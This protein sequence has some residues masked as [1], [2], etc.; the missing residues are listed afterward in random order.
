MTATMPR[1]RSTDRRYYGLASALVERVEDPEHE[2]RVTLRFPWFDEG[3][4]ESDWCRVNQ[5]YAGNGYGSLFVP[6]HGDEVLVAFVH[7]D[8]REPIVLGGLYN[9]KDKPASSRTADRD[10]KLIRT[11]AGHRVL[12]DDTAQAHAVKV[13]T[14]GGHEVVLDD[15][16]QGKAIRAVTSGGHELILDDVSGTVAITGNGVSITLAD[17]GTVT[18]SGATVKVEASVSIELGAPAAIQSAVLGESLM[19]L[20]NLHTHTLV[21]PIPI[22]TTPPI[23]PMTQLQLSTKV[24]VAQA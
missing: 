13:T 7:G 6:E 23:T 24:K 19:A 3:R 1:S 21:P 22:P 5:L 15:T 17:T 2:G 16:A 11:K 4:T 20:F 14:A 10:Q 8:M 9:G 18:I 12:L